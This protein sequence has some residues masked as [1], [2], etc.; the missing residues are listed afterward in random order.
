MLYQ[1]VIVLQAR[2]FFIAMD[3]LSDSVMYRVLV[4]KAVDRG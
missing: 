3:S 2:S 1:W 4:S